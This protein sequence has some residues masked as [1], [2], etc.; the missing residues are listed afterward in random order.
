MTVAWVWGSAGLLGAALCRALRAQGSELFSPAQRF[1]WDEPAVLSDQVEA[2]VAAFALQAQRSERWEIHWAA[3]VGTMGSPAAALAPETLALSLLLDLL[4]GQAWVAST[5][6]VIS[7]ASSAGAIYAGSA[8]DVITENSAPA[9]TTAYAAEKLKQEDLVRCFVAAN[10][11]TTALIARISTLYGAGQAHGKKQGLL[12]YISRSIIR[13]QPVQIYV[14]F[15]TIRDYIDA[16]DA[17]RAMLGS[18]SATGQPSGVMLKIIASETPTT[19]AE[20]IAIFKRLSRRTP[21]VVR[22]AN[23]LSSLYTRRVQ[24]KSIVASAHVKLPGKRLPVGISELMRAEH[25]AFIKSPRPTLK[26]PP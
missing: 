21:L 25:L 8:D 2:A 20:I 17:A 26:N 22:S 3:G 1:S 16:D 6:G 23:K 19:I 24:F 5:R 7:F 18:A 9:P 4:N 13:N 11:S 15:D 14:P 10:P 12:G